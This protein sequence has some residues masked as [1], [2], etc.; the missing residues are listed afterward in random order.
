VQLDWITETETLNDYFSVERSA[1]GLSWEEITQI[2]GMGT[3]LDR[4]SYD[5][6]DRNPFL[7]QSYYRLKQIDFDGQFSYSNIETVNFEASQNEVYIYPNP[8]KK[9]LTIE[10]L[11]SELK[12]FEIFNALGQNVSQQSSVLNNSGTQLILDLSN[13]DSGIYFF[14]TENTNNK[15]CKF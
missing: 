1:D 7:G 12:H 9:I 13:L 6:Q 10:G 11:Q 2:K 14:K 3:T 15:F 8:T 5:Y 4:Q